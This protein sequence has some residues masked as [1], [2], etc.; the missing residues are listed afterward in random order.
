MR[1]TLLIVALASLVLGGCAHPDYTKATQVL[2]AVERGQLQVGMTLDEVCAVINRTPG[3]PDDHL[4]GRDRYWYWYMGEVKA[5]PRNGTIVGSVSP[6][7]TIWVREGRSA[8]FGNSA[9]LGFRDG[10][11]YVW[12]VRTAEQRNAGDTWTYALDG[13]PEN[14]TVDADEFVRRVNAPLVASRDHD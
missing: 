12:R 8:M 10:R 2:R 1:T 11:L 4:Y 3:G 13:N 9:S 6:S 7:G 5:L 14:R